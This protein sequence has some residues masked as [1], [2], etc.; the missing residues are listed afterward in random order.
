MKNM[1]L[2]LLMVTVSDG[3][4]AQKYLTKTGHIGFYSHTPLEDIIADNNQ[5]ASILDAE[6]NELVFQALMRSFIFQ[7]A[8]MQEHFNENYVESEKYPKAEF[9]G[10]IIAPGDLDL[11]KKGSYDVTVQGDLTLHGVTRNVK[12]PGKIQVNDGDIS[13]HSEFVVKPEDFDIQIPGVV[14]EKIAKEITVKVDMKYL[15]MK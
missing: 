15:P 11:S 5:V 1:M 7:R 8:L 13:A 3:L 12:V 4:S 2:I 14:R 9:N 10:K 6:K